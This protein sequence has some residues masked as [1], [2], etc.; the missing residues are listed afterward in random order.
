[1]AHVVLRTDH[2][3]TLSVLSVDGHN[4]AAHVTAMQLDVDKD[5]GAAVWVKVPADTLDVDAHALLSAEADRLAADKI[6]AIDPEWLREQV[7]RRTRTVASDPFGLALDV[8]ADAL[9]DDED[10]ES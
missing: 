3:G 5:G 2:T 8:I 6:R 9:A 1:M 10:D 7:A 4:L